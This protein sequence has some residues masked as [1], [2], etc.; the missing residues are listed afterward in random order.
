MNTLQTLADN[1]LVRYLILILISIAGVAGYMAA[2][3]LFSMEKTL[4]DVNGL[5]Q[6]T[7][8][9][10]ATLA[11]S[12]SLLVVFGG[13]L[14]LGG[15]FIDK[16][17]LRISGIVSSLILVV[18]A[19]L[20]AYSMFD[21][22]ILMEQ[23]VDIPVIHFLGTQVRKPILYG[24]LGFAL[25]G[26]GSEIIGVVQT[27]VLSKWFDG[28]EL[29]IALA[30]QIAISRVG[31]GLTYGLTPYIVSLY[32]GNVSVPMMITVGFLILGLLLYLAYCICDRKLDNQFKAIGKAEVMTEE[33]FNWSDL[34]S[35]VR[36]APFWAVCIIC[37]F[38]YG[39]VK[40]FDKYSTGFMS[41]QL[42]IAQASEG[43]F[44]MT[45]CLT[46]AVVTP[47]LG[48]LV[49]KKGRSLDFLIAGSLLATIDFILLDWVQLSQPLFYCVYVLNGLS[50]SFIAAALWPL[51]PRI[52][53][54]AVQG[55][56]FAVV[57][58]FQNIM[59]LIVPKFVEAI[60]INEP[61]FVLVFAILALISTAVSLIFK[62]TDRKRNW[63]LNL[64]EPQEEVAQAS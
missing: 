12:Y 52:L 57:F 48:I 21:L 11:G 58:L 2:E 13:V 17:G 25:F 60:G 46:I 31:I 44:T 50:F 14:I 22:R 29:A 35:I 64:P 32:N 40:M 37:C 34:K 41:S 30:V 28:K 47:L 8:A 9:E 63:G 24:I 55:T 5:Y 19:G 36:S 59:F 39:S 42:G 62:M 53:D 51:V 54:L 33:A 38:F 61:H 1:K 3:V 10:Y 26:A 6:V 49:H 56:G 23:G 7:D 18:G 43:L 45:S 27:K 16:C 20:V 15:L 4:I